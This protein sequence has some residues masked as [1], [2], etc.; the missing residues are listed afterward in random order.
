[1]NEAT[2]FEQGPIRPPNEAGS[3]LIRVSRNCPWNR[4]LF[5]PIYKFDRFSRRSTEEIKEDIDLMAR[6]VD[7]VKEL[8]GQN[9]KE[10]DINQNTLAYFYNQKPDLFPIAHWLYHGEQSV[11]LQDAD[12]II[13]KGDKLAEIVRYIKEKIP[14]VSRITTYARVKSLAK[15]SVEELQ[16]VKEAGLSRVHVGLESG[17]DQVLEFMQK[18]VT[19]AEQIEAGQKVIDAGLILSEY[20]ILGL[21]GRDYWQEHAAETARV[22]N[23]INPHYI[24]LRTL[25]IHPAA[26]LAEEWKNGTFEPLSDE[27]ILKEERLLLEQLEGI[28]S[29]LYSDHILNLLEEVQGKLPD[30]K[31]F[32]LQVI[33]NYF[34]LKEKERN[35]FRLGRRAGLLRNLS[36]L[37]NIPR[38]GRVEGIYKDL[39][40][41]GL[42]VDQF[43]EDIRT[44]YL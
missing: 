21:G 20:V 26:P 39:Q 11:F 28:H 16:E 6:Y 8:A 13:Y 37:N 29:A 15:R 30:S 24:R 1:L 38:R 22:L 19:A 12:N 9:N 18:G 7:E 23:A 4:C 32:M 41:K 40:K 34:N 43:I 44:K 36:E 3:L 17:S 33:D 14:G 10:G 5:C 27:E 42:T 25:A 2:T 35:L 31:K